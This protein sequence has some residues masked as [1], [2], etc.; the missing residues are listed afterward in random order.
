MEGNVELRAVEPAG[1]DA[2]RCIQAYFAEIDRRS[3]T[4]FDPDSSLP[5]EPQDFLPLPAPSWS[6]T[7]GTNRWVAEA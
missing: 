6:P 2:Q 1:R 3:D 5:A 4:G 7:S